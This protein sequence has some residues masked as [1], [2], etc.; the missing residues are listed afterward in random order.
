MNNDE[1]LEFG[2][3]EYHGLY[4]AE[5]K[6]EYINCD[7][8]GKSGLKYQFEI[9]HKATGETKHVGSEC[10]NKY[11]VT[12]ID[13]D[14]TELSGK[15]LSDKLKIDKNKL[16]KKKEIDYVVSCLLNL[17]SKNDEF[18]TK[19]ILDNFIS[20]YLERGAF[21]PKQYYLIIS[22]FK[23]Y[24]I[25]YKPSLFKMIIKRKR[26]QNQLFEMKREGLVTIFKNIP[27]SQK[28]W[29][30][31]NSKKFKHISFKD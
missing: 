6:E 12:I 16:I 21:T 31:K 8:C 11:E 24:N 4:I 23:Y 10:I 25:I 9:I 7:L 1:I 15:A 17:L 30:K 19:D 22:K 3:W 13:I 20:Y 28:D 5:N 27:Q 26:E 14:G 29:M 2:K 18:F